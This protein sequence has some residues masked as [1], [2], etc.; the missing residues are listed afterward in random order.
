MIRPIFTAD[1]LRLGVSVNEVT[2]SI[3]QF[4]SADTHYLGSLHKTEAFTNA[5]GREGDIQMQVMKGMES[6]KGKPFVQWPE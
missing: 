1:A 4:S 5:E 6:R 3:F 2:E